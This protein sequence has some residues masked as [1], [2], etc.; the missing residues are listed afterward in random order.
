MSKFSN[1]IAPHV[2]KELAAASDCR[3]Q[4]SAAREFQHLENAHVLGQNSTYWHTLVHLKMLTW[5]V[6]NASF[7]EFFGQMLRIVGAATK[8][9]IG[10]VPEGNT[11]GSNISPFKR[12]PIAPEFRKIIE[13]AKQQGKL[14]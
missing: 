5:S 1:Y 7:Q 12:L 9:A 6:R 3:L 4:Q 13:D 14:A 2:E 11:G 10:L 8:T